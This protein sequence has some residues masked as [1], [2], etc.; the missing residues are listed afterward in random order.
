MKV[1][2]ELALHVDWETVL[3]FMDDHHTPKQVKRIRQFFL[4][5]REAPATDE[6]EMARLLY[7]N[8][9][10]AS[11]PPFKELLV[12]LN[13]ATLRAFLIPNDRQTSSPS[14]LALIQRCERAYALLY[15][16]SE[17]SGETRIKHWQQ[18]VKSTRQC[19]HVALELECLQV[20]Q[21]IYG[22]RAYDEALL[23][24]TEAEIR[25]CIN[26]NRVS[27]RCK[28]AAMD[29]RVASTEG[30]PYPADIPLDE[31]RVSVEQNKL[32]D[33]QYHGGELLTQNAIDRKDWPAALRHSERA[34][35]FFRKHFPKERQPPVHF[36]Y[37]R[38]LIFTGLLDFVNG[39]ACWEQLLQLSRT[40]RNN[41]QLGKVV[42][43]GIIL[44]LR[45]GN[46]ETSGKLLRVIEDG[47]GTDLI[48]K[49][50]YGRWLTYFR[51]LT[52]LNH[53]RPAVLEMIAG[54]ERKIRRGGETIRF[55]PEDEQ[56]IAIMDCMLLLR[57]QSFRKAAGIISKLRNKL[58]KRLSAGAPD[59]RLHLFIK[60][61]VKSGTA[62]FH[63]VAT[64][65][66][67]EKTLG[68]LRATTPGI[69]D[70]GIDVE[71]IPFERLW[72]MILPTLTEKAPRR[73]YLPA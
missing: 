11:H 35:S 62:N 44:V 57:E 50:E 55:H 66:K 61:L 7:G 67:T 3:S 5:L 29:Q 1:L 12:K 16:T 8:S 27:T 31:V 17:R 28:I 49:R 37:S 54:Q 13:F 19:H 48:P 10:T 33:I 23:E 56:N 58:P 6:A 68:R 20:L 52:L 65:R 15:T 36:L 46:A 71:L 34:L 24:E 21:A 70:N 4:R 25:R 73:P 69:D 42:E 41:G 30:K 2:R 43:V 22:Y 40:Y 32:Y 72:E 47:G 26:K 18:L 64:L 51:G 9:R 59:Y 63:R 60:L 14:R 39:W 38:V 45:C 53:T